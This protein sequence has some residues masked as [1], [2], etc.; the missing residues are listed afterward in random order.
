M[1]VHTIKKRVFKNK[2]EREIKKKGPK[3]RPLKVSC[4]SKDRMKKSKLI[5]KH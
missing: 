2:K 4:Q 3:S 1:V 5:M